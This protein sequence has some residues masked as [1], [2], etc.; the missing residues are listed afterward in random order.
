LMC[1]VGKLTLASTLSASTCCAM[2][3]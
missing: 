3:A 2:L 1:K